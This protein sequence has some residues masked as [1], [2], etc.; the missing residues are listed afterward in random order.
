MFETKTKAC[1]AFGNN[2]SDVSDN[3][4]NKIPWIVWKSALPCIPISMSSLGVVTRMTKSLVLLLWRNDSLKLNVEAKRRSK[5]KQNQTVNNLKCNRNTAAATG[6][7]NYHRYTDYDCKWLFI[8][9]IEWQAMTKISLTQMLMYTGML[10]Y[11]CEGDWKIQSLHLL[12]FNCHCRFFVAF[13]A[14]DVVVAYMRVRLRCFELNTTIFSSIHFISCTSTLRYHW[15]PPNKRKMPTD[16][17][18]K[19]YVGLKICCEQW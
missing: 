13:T 17:Q 11:G 7:G 15:P 9:L 16:N 5:A 2:G 6:G 10:R 4:V 19:F 12:K 8:S 3:S 1:L 14:F 18:W